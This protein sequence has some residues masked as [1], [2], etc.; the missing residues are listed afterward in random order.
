MDETLHALGNLLIQSIPTITFF[1]ILVAFLNRTYFR[2][3]AKIFEERRKA[4]EG[5]RELARKAFEAADKK[6]AEFEHALQV[7]RG[8]LHQEH[9]ALR[10]RWAEEQ[11]AAI[12]NARA[13]ADAQIARAK[14]DIAQEVARTQAELDAQVDALGEQIATSL[15][16]RRAA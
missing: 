5:V 8:Q 3:I 9:E 11:A 13:E 12:A 10:R 6:T 1:V 4:T 16:R 2:P 14:Q 15:M 7:A